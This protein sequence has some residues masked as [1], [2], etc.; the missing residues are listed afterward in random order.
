VTTAG[1]VDVVLQS[2]GD[3]VER[4]SPRP[5]PLLSLHRTGGFY[6]L[7]PRHCDEGI[8][9]GI[10][11]LNALQASLRKVDGRCILAAKQL[12]NFLQ[13]QAGQVLRFS[14]SRLQSQ[15]DDRISGGYK[16]ASAAVRV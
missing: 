15:A 12:R 16:K 11:S 9:C 3:T 6:R 2:D 13:R 1:G 8:Q 10:I 14:K 4:S 5:L 7:I